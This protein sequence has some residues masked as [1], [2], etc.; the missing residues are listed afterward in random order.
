MFGLGPWEIAVVAGA[1]L[2]VAGPALLP[3]IGGFVGKSLTG[4]RESAVSFSTNLREEMKS[5]PE[6]PQLLTSEVEAPASE[7]PAS[8]ESHA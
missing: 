2:L 5:E 4:L 6:E 8:R 1:V 3:K 7:A